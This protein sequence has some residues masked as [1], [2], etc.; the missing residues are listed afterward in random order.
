[1]S[2]VF[3]L[4]VRERW[5]ARSVTVENWFKKPGDVFKA[6]DEV[7]RVNI[8]GQSRVLTYRGEDTCG[9]Y[10][11]YVRE[12]SEVGPWGYLLEHTDVAASCEKFVSSRTFEAAPMV[13]RRRDRYPK[14][15]LSYRKQDADAYAGRLHEVLA[16]AFGRDEVF[17]DM[18]SIRGGEIF[19]WTI[20]QAVAH[21]DVVV[22]LIGPKWFS[23]ADSQ[24]RP[25]LENEW[26]F[27]RR[28]LSAARDRGTTILP[29]LLPGAV[30]PENQ[31]LWKYDE[32]SALTDLQMSELSARHWDVD[33]AQIVTDIRT[34]ISG[35]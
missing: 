10:R 24:G 33:V 21:A 11:H 34:A 13:F 1:V 9:V 19:S 2:S 23:V 12:G 15:F 18:F 32:L 20:Q 4:N 8:D 14:V 29:V 28:E 22:A 6:G 26:D 5:A 3:R 35:S 27:V 30:I 25:R 17:M 31:T 7:V 16:A